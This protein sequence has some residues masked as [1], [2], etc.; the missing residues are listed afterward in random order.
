[1]LWDPMYIP[2]AHLCKVGSVSSNLVGNDP[3]LDVVPVGQA[4]MLLGRHI[5]QQ[6]RSCRGF[7]LSPPT[8]PSEP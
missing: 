2:E 3:S 4:Q 5:A 7:E 6:R 8:L 1:M